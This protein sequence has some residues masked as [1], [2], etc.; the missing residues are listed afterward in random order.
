MPRESKTRTTLS[1]N[2]LKKS[3]LQNPIPFPDKNVQKLGIEET[4]LNMIK[5][6]Y[7]KIH[8]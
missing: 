3:I 5:G 2:K 6:I 4:L 7:K 1:S 8:S